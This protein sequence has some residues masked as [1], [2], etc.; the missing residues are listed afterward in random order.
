M[1]FV[2]TNGSCDEAL[3]GERQQAS[4]MG[5][6]IEGAAYA[7]IHRLGMAAL[8]R[9]VALSNSED[10][11][12]ALSATTEI[13]NRAFGKISANAARAEKS[14]AGAP[15]VQVINFADWLDQHKEEE[16]DA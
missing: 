1:A 3:L 5:G 13:L 12:I 7:L 11:K 8:S 6:P 10:E 2:E 15:V 4:E 16:E 14:A 9:L